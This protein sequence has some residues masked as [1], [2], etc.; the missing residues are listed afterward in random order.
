MVGCT[1]R[2][3]GLC[4]PCHRPKAGD[5]GSRPGRPTRYGEDDGSSRLEQRVTQAAEASLVEQGTS[6]PSYVLLRLGWLAPSQAGPVAAGSGR[7]AWSGRCSAGMCKQSTAMLTLRTWA[8]RRGLTPSE[9]AYV[10]R[11]EIAA[12][13]SSASAASRHRAG[14]SHAL[15]LPQAVRRKA[16]RLRAAANQPPDLVV[17]DPL[18][19]WTAPAAPLPAPACSSCRTTNRTACLRPARPSGL[20]AGRLTRHAP[21]G[22]I[23]PAP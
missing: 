14:L 15:G 2:W 21:G 23:A 12:G 8:T 3:P 20:H 6:A 19:E 4:C 18:T 16:E 11:P 1:R 13:C 9:T 22:R 5:I 7:G 10:A 17:V